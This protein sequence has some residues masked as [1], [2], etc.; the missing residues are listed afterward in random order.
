MSRIDKWSNEEIELLDLYL[1]NGLRWKEISER[2]N[3]TEAAVR[4]AAARFGIS[5]PKPKPIWTEEQLERLT[6][7]AKAGAG[8]KQI[9]KAVGRSY[10]ATRRKLDEHGYHKIEHQSEIEFRTLCWTCSRSSGKHMCSWALNFRPIDG[11][12]TT[13][14]GDEDVSHDVTECPLFEEEESVS[15][16][17]RC[18]RNGN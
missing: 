15:A 18:V 13:K 16:K 8:I 3:R 10:D 14:R 12:K 17:K 11:W 1:R 7:M 6:I 4:R 5:K 9:S 2:L